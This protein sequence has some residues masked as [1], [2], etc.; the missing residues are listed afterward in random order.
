MHCATARLRLFAAIGAFAHQDCALVFVFTAM[1]SLSESVLFP[2]PEETWSASTVMEKD[3]EK[4]VDDLVL[5]QKNII[6]WR[7]ASGELFP[8]TDTNEI[9]V[10]E[11]FFYRGF[12]LSTSAFFHGLLHW[13]GIELVHLNPNLI[14]HNAT[15]IHLCE[16][17]LG[18]RPYFNLFRYFFIV[19]PSL[20]D[21]KL[22]EV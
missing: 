14:L 2:N 12:A 3:L 16:V 5:P 20:T 9:V 21:G 22:N 13:Y 17:F 6:G 1:S 18:I 19:N 4:M 7:A 15:F 8:T 11:H 10:F